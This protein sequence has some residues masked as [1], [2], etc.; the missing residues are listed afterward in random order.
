MAIILVS[1]QFCVGVIFFFY[2]FQRLGAYVFRLD[3]FLWQD[4]MADLKSELGGALAKVILG[5]M[6]TPAQYDAKQL[7]KAMEV[8]QHFKMLIKIT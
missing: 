2:L 7:K 6:M 3:C 4:L 8:K 5:L 1:L